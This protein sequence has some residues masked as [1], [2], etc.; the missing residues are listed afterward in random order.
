M[1]PNSGIWTEDE[2][3]ARHGKTKNAV[4][5]ERYMGT[6]PKFFHSGRRV[7]YRVQDVLD[8]EESRLQER[9]GEKA[10]A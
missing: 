8:W 5:Q 7:F 1:E 10:S 2:Y 9:T 3:R 4:R 6:G